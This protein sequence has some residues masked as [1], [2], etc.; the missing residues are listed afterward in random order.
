MK[1]SKKLSKKV[2][3]K[4]SKQLF[5][6]PSPKLP[7]KP[8]RSIALSSL[9]IVALLVLT[10]A[11][12]QASPTDQLQPVGST[13]LKVMFWTIYD[14]TLFTNNGQYRGVEPG[15]A[16]KIDYRRN[17][18]RDHLI[19]TT[20]DQWQE[21]GLYDPGVSE[22]WLRALMELWPNIR[23]GD[24]ITLVVEPDM[25]ASFY[26]NGVSLGRLSDARFTESFLA[27]WLAENSTFPKLR[28]QLIGLN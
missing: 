5:K 17:I 12:A 4:V 11:R 14:S 7:M 3:K 26:H 1:L 21:L 8:T 20:R 2:L 15:L 27:I 6:T 24:S 25:S 28:D 9:L 19:G 16:L 18:K 22:D 10:T 13:T 23:R